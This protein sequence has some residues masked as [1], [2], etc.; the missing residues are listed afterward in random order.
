MPGFFLTVDERQV[1]DLQREFRDVQNVLDREVPPAV[2]R[3]VENTRQDVVSRMDA[4]LPGVRKMDIHNATKTTKATPA[5]WSGQVEMSGPGVPVGNLDVRLGQ[6]TEVTEI[7][8]EKQSA[9]LFHNVFKPKYGAAAMYSTAYRIKRMVY[10]NITYRVS[11]QVK[12][13]AGMGAFPMPAKFGRTGIFKRRKGFGGIREKLTEMRG[14][15]LFD[16]FDQNTAMMRDIVEEN[17]RRFE[18]DL[19]SMFDGRGVDL[20]PRIPIKRLTD[21]GV[22]G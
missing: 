11:G 7:A 6:P 15:S 17:T 20:I 8:S 16:I 19:E 13:L 2:N 21:P 3:A 5:N 1:R 10:N 14:P 18:R 9:W 12:S 22:S 4:D